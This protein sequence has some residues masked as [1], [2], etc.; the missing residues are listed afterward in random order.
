MKNLYFLT[1]FALTILCANQ[2]YAQ[3]LIVSTSTG[4]NFSNN[5]SWIGGSAPLDT[6][7]V[8]ISSGATITCNTA[9]NNMRNLIVSSG[10]T[11]NTGNNNTTIN[12]TA[13]IYGIFTL[14]NNSGIRT[15]VGKLTI[16]PGANFNDHNDPQTMVFKG[17]IEC[18][19]PTT[20]SKTTCSF[21]TNDQTLSGNSKFSVFDVSTTSIILTNNSVAG[22]EIQNKCGGNGTLKQGIGSLLIFPLT[23]ALC[24]P[25]VIYDFTASTN[26]VEFKFNNDFYLIPTVYSVVK[27]SQTN[28]NGGF[29]S[30]GT[31]T[32][33]DALVISNTTSRI[34]SKI[35]DNGTLII[36]G[37]IYNAGRLNTNLAPNV[38]LIFKGK[39]ISGAGQFNLS[40]LTFENSF[41]TG[42]VQ[43]A[44]SI[45]I[46]GK[47]TNYSSVDVVQT[48]GNFQSPTGSNVIIDGTSNNLY[49]RDL[50]LIGTSTITLQ[51]SVYIW[52]NL[53]LDE[54]TNL[55]DISS[56]TLYLLGTV[57]YNNGGF[58]GGNENSTLYYSPTAS[59]VINFATKRHY[60]KDFISAPNGAYTLTLGGG[61]DVT[62]TNYL[63]L[64]KGN[65]ALSGKKLV[66]AQNSSVVR[67]LG[68][69]GAYPGFNSRYSVIYQ[70]PVTAGLELPL[71]SST[72]KDLTVMCGVGNNVTLNSTPSINGSLSIVSGGFVASGSNFIKNATS[73]AIDLNN[74][75]IHSLPVGTNTKSVID[76]NTYATK[77]GTM[78]LNIFQG[79]Y[80]TISTSTYLN[81][82]FVVSGVIPTKYDVSVTYLVADVVGTESNLY[83]KFWNGT[84]WLSDGLVNTISHKLNFSN[85]NVGGTLT[86]FDNTVNLNDLETNNSLG[87]YPNPIL[88]SAFLNINNSY[89]GNLNI[90]VYDLTGKCIKTTQLYKSAENFNGTMDF[91][92]L[93]KGIYILKVNS[94]SE[95]QTIKLIKN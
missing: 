27:L 46:Y 80:P 49:I 74:N 48:S 41:S 51:T 52:N 22:F 89:L 28:D 93:K 65:L 82:Y 50:R 23:T 31:T 61:N 73:I 26:T 20:I 79:K 15:F 87:L 11:I 92:Y 59:C 24:S 67:K 63:V 9:N 60:L 4:G 84:Q 85:L 78:I 75:T 94:K 62:V 56:S 1:V 36:N 12:G 72:L 33:N 13:D 3:R 66:M 95:N 58:L 91:S 86:A 10:A 6:D 81:K 43:I 44:S 76:L 39:L 69:V 16:H 8:S 70:N 29:I 68:S 38:K 35:T 45:N 42:S 37:N 71:L 88:N 7:D 55:L 17:G 25:T 21:T 5:A 40:N 19:N 57:S 54:A 77:S 90:E 18:N 2:N 64:E 83:S 34:D 32:I 30:P 14:G 47:I 53:Y